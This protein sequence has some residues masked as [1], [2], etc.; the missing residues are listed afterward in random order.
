MPAETVAEALERALADAGLTSAEVTVAEIYQLSPAES[1]VI[2]DEMVAGAEFP[3][4]LVGERVACT[5]AV[6]LQAVLEATARA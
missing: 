1:S 6:D 3:M 2:I 5:G 4:V